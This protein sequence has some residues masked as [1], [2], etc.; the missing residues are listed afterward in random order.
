[1]DKVPADYD[2]LQTAQFLLV[3]PVQRHVIKGP[4]NSTYIAH[5]YYIHRIPR[6]QLL[7][8]VRIYLKYSP[9]LHF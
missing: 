4:I 5:R 6:Y 7:V 3:M 1:M 9:P 8:V 2:Q